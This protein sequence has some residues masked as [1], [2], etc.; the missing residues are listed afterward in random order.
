MLHTGKS[1]PSILLPIKFSPNA[2][3]GTKEEVKKSPTLFRICTG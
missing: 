1:N 2:Q 3:N